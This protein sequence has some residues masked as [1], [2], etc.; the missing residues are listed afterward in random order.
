MLEELALIRN[1]GFAIDDEE[2]QVGLRCIGAPIRDA[3]G[4]V[5]AAVSVSGPAERMPDARLSGLAPL[6]IQTANDISEAL[7]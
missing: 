5:F 3:T 1:S 2:N 6:V 7:S 4:R